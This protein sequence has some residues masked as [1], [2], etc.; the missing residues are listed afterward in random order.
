MLLTETCYYLENQVFGG[1]S[2][3]DMSLIETCF[4]L[5]LNGR[6]SEFIFEKGKKK[7]RKYVKRKR[8]KKGEKWKRGMEKIKIET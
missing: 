7:R 2:N 4:Y 6:I 1:V 3:R 5:P 8:K